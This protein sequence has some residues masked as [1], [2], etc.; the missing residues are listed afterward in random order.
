MY[1]IGVARIFLRDFIFYKNNGSSW[2]NLKKCLMGRALPSQ[3]QWFFFPKRGSFASH[4]T[5]WCHLCYMYLYS[6]LFRICRS[7]LCCHR[8]PADWEHSVSDNIPQEDSAIYR[9][10]DAQ[11]I[12]Q[13]HLGWP[14]WPE[15]V[16]QD[17]W[18]CGCWSFWRYLRPGTLHEFGP[19]SKPTW[20]L[21]TG[22][23]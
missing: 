16:P 23:Q 2:S 5:H 3:F 15:L 13:Y 8:Q 22:K 11:F 1:I 10:V 19:D 20:G 21:F 14:Q 17:H 7:S 9:A 4:W 18:M 12:C 6:R